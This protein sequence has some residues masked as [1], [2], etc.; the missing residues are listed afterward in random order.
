MTRTMTPARY[1][2]PGKPKAQPRHRHGNGRT[3]D[4]AK[5]AKEEIAWLIHEQRN[6]EPFRGALRVDFTFDHAKG[7]GVTMVVEEIE[8]GRIKRPD[9][10]NLAKFYMDASNGILWADDA[11]VAELIAR[12][13]G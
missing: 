10:D 1:Y 2:F 13:I 9:I 3:W 12:K 6:H 4:P 8:E 5:A 11:Q 7:R